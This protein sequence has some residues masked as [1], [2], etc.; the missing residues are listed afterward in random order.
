MNK[1]WCQSNTD[2][3]EFKH[4]YSFFPKKRKEKNSIKKERVNKPTTPFAFF[5]LHKMSLSPILSLG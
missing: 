2:V 4:T 1:I 5:F 3:L